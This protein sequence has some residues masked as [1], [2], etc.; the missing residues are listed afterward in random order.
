[1]AKSEPFYT[2]LISVIIV[3]NPENKSQRGRYTC[4]FD[5]GALK[6]FISQ[7]V[8]IS[9]GLPVTDPI[10]CTSII[11]GGKY[12][13]QGYAVNVHFPKFVSFL[14]ANCYDLPNNVFPPNID[15]IVGMDII[16]QGNFAIYN[17][18]RNNQGQFSFGK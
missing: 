17:V 14:P 1:M 13:S 4:L 6:T 15:M 11:G 5:T 3:S 10:G 16:S 12:H 7:R 9:L 8:A 18:T 2:R